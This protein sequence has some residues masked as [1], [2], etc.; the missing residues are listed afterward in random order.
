L[1]DELETLRKV[2]ELSPEVADLH[3]ALGDM[4]LSQGRI[5]EAEESLVNAY[6][7]DSC[8]PKVQELLDQIRERR[9]RGWLE[10]KATEEV[11]A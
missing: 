11:S 4:L 5:D 2:I 1:I 10:T 6:R 7:L 8:H 9:S 3:L